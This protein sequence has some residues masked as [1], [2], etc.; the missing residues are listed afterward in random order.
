MS[1]SETRKIC[2]RFISYKL[3]SLALCIPFDLFIFINF[4]FSMYQCI[5]EIF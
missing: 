5:L 1:A 2:V 4:V 3:K